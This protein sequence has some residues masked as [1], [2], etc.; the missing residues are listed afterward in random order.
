MQAVFY[1]A[2]ATLFCQ[3]LARPSIAAGDRVAGKIG[4]ADA[5]VRTARLARDKL[6]R[7]VALGFGAIFGCQ[8]LANLSMILGL[9]PIVGIPLP[10]VSYGG[11]SV[12]ATL[13]GIGLVLNVRMRR[14]V[15]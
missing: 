5:L 6:G 13:I 1:A 14:F 10:L 4:T 15:N 2:L 3:D 11:S 12:V 9:V 7:Y 8:V